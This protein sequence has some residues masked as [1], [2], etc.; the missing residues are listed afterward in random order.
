MADHHYYVDEKSKR[1]LQE[2]NRIVRAGH[3][4]SRPTPTRRTPRGGGGGGGGNLAEFAID[5]NVDPGADYDNATNRY[6]PVTFLVRPIHWV[7]D[8][9][10]YEMKLGEGDKVRV[11][12]YMPEPIKMDP[13][14]WRIGIG[15]LVSG[16]PF[17]SDPGFGEL[18]EPLV[19]IKLLNVSCREFD[20]PTIPP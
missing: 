6:T 10:E 7:E 8:T 3:V 2:I 19:T 12:S 4:S 20:M 15:Q 18:D 1:R 14:K 16:E 11:I 5:E 9:Q 13:N 17:D